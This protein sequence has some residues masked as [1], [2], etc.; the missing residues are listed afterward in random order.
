MSA[1]KQIGF[2]VISFSLYDAD[3]AELGARVHDLRKNGLPSAS[4]SKLIRVAL[5]YLYLNWP[6]AI[7]ILRA[8]Q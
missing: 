1:A 2:K 5:R 4:R 7:E 6:A 8:G 3:I